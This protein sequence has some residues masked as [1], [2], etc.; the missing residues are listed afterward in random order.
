[1]VWR[2]IRGLGCPTSRAM[3]RAW[4]VRQNQWRTAIFG[5]ARPPPLEYRPGPRRVGR[6]GRP[7]RG[8]WPLPRGSRARSPAEARRAGERAGG[9]PATPR[10][11]G[12]GRESLQG[13]RLGPGWGWVRRVPGRGRAPGWPGAR[14]ACTA[15][16]GGR[17]GRPLGSAGGGPLPASDPSRPRT[18]LRV[19]LPSRR[20]V[21]AGVFPGLRRASMETVGEGKPT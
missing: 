15:G 11:R 20:G 18:P 4:R 1:M 10:G 12:P 19:P 6:L 8:C 16:A 2:G 3:C 21:E 9:R 7:P 17:P 14:R 13:P 5:D